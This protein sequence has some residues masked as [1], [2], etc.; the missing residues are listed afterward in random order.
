MFGLC[1]NISA[2]KSRKT[3]SLKNSQELANKCDSLLCNDLQNIK[4]NTV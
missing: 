1:R 3:T 4:Q 2:G